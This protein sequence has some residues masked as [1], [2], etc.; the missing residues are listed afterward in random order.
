VTVFSDRGRVRYVF[1]GLIALS[2]TAAALIATVGPANAAGY[3]PGTTDP[4]ATAAASDTA[5]GSGQVHLNTEVV[6][7]SAADRDLVVKVRLAGLWEGPAGRMAARKGFE[8]RVRQIGAMIAAQHTQLDALDKAA[9][10]KLDVVLPT[11]PTDEQQRWLN[12]MAKA[13]G[14]TFDNI[15]V[16]RLRAAHGKIFPAIGAVRAGTKNEVVRALAQQANNFVLNHLT[17]LES[18]GLVQYPELPH[19][20][21]PAPGPVAAVTTSSQSGGIS[22]PMIWLI[23]AVALIGGAAATAKVLRPRAFGGRH[24]DFPEPVPVQRVTATR[25]DERYPSLYPPQRP[26]SRGNSRSLL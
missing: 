19:L 26:R 7:L 18:T 22:V 11:K 17:Y 12:E 25:P 20:A 5:D 3:D 4:A 16:M 6:P 24:A 10:A 15:F 8:P 23:L 14:K 21:A 13:K 1:H 9:A 2:V